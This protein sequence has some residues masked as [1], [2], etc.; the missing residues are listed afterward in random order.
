MRGG[1][2]LR[3]GN[4]EEFLLACPEKLCNTEG[5][6]KGSKVNWGYFLNHF[7]LPEVY[8]VGQNS[9][10]SYSKCFRRIYQ[11]QNINLETI[12]RHFES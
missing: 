11:N 4:T 8:K 6:N 12:S 7:E 10:R 5:N 1:N 9:V 2:K 3:T